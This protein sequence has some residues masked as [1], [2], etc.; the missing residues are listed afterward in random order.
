MSYFT[1][2]GLE[3]ML[4]SEIKSFQSSSSFDLVNMTRLKFAILAE[5]FCQ[6]HIPPMSQRGSCSTS[7]FTEEM[8]QQLNGI[9]KNDVRGFFSRLLS[10]RASETCVAMSLLFDPNKSPSLL[11]C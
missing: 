11:P 2:L 10:G 9:W 8:I 1:A 5:H 7:A 6:A 4:V 3:S